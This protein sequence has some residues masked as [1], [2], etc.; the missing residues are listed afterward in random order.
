MK[1]MVSVL[2][3]ILVLCV[4]G[5]AMAQ[6][7]PWLQW[8]LLP[9]KILNEIIGESSGEN[10]YYMEME[11]GGYDKNRKAE[12]YQTM[13][14]ETKFY[15]DKLKEYGLPGVE[16]VRFPGGQTWDGVKGDLWEVSPIRQKLA[17][18]NDMAAML[19]SGSQ[20]GEYEGE[21]VWIGSGSPADLQGKNLAGK[22][23][24]TTG[25]LG[26]RDT[27]VLGVISI[28]N[29]RPYFDPIQ[30]NWGSV[31]RQVK[32]GF[33]IP[34][35]EGETLIRRLQRGDRIVAHASVVAE[36]YTVDHQEVLWNIPGTDP[37]AGEV[38]FSAHLFEGYQKQGGNDDI[39]GCASI[40]EVGRVL[41]T[42]IREGRIPQPKRTIR[43]IMGPEI[44]GTGAWVSANKE[45]M[46]KTLCNINLDMVG[47]WLTKNKAFFCLMRTT[48]GNPHYINDVMENYYRF[49]GEGSRERIQNRSNFNKVLQRIV[50]PTG[51]D[52]PFYYSIETF[53][54]SSDHTVFNDWG[55]QVP[56]IMMIAWPDQWYHTSGDHVDK[57]DPTQLR[58]VAVIAAAGAYTIANA[59]DDMAIKIA[60]EIASNGTDRIGHQFVR[61]LEELNNATAENLADAYKMARTY[62]EGGAINEKNTLETVNQLAVDKKRVGDYVISMQRTMDGIVIYHLTALDANMKEAAR[63][64]HTQP[65]VLP[66]SDLEKK[67]MTVLYK[68]TPKVKMNGRGGY[69]Q[70]I[71]AVPQDVRDKY[72]YRGIDSGEC[73]RMVNGR[74]SALDIKKLL[75]TQG[76]RPADLQAVLNYLEILREAGLIEK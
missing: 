21:L 2:V 31:S 60:G 55:V 16:L 1:K 6:L 20:T 69:S 65:V 53:Y 18:Y 14:Y 35:R 71:S 23:A 12:E 17:S 57:S 41:N 19:A 15:L 36:R 62:V 30:L 61:G 44:S 39:S 56:G 75:D 24:V 8:S 73:Q 4:A 76:Q 29:S 11:T 3:C 40:V 5:G 42:L 27:T 7:T 59:D 46:A 66:L 72:P 32:F 63:R 13:F 26:V 10:A 74:N 38:I 34:P 47:E 45:L 67:A 50:A 43:F 25:S 54:G 37:N 64:L 51:V 70:F 49:V 68:Q 28:T 58:R 9:P 33:Q 52:E 48:F 22:I